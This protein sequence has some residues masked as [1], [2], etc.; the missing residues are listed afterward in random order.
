MRHSAASTTLNTYAELWP[1]QDES[2]RAAV[3][4]VMSEKMRDAVASP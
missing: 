2:T 1:D 4:K 3:E